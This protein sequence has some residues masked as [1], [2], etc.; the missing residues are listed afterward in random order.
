MR[1]AKK[2]FLN[3]FL[4][5][6]GLL[7]ICVFSYGLVANKLGYFLDDWYI[8]WTYRTFG[9]EKFLDFFKGD[10]PLFSYVY[11]VFIPLIKDSPL[12]WQLFAIFTK[13]LSGISLWCLLRL[14]MP[15]KDLSTFAIT[16]LFLVYPGFKFHHFAVMYSQNYAILAVYFLSHIFMI[17]AIRNPK[18]RCVYTI[19][20][21][22]LQFIGI[23][24]MELYYGL[25]LVRPILIFL[26]LRDD[27][28][29]LKV[30]LTRSFKTWLPY[31]LVLFG[32]TLFR[33]GFGQLYSYQLGLVNQL[34]SD[35]ISTIKQLAV[36]V[37]KAL[38]DS[39]F[40]VW[41][42][43][44]RQFHAAI[45]SG[46]SIVVGV[47]VAAGL[48]ALL[49][50]FYSHRTNRTTDSRIT[51]F[52]LPV[53]GVYI[54]LVGMIPVLI[55]GLDIGL[56]FHNN[57][58]LLHLSVGVCILIVSLVDLIIRQGYFRL[59]LLALLI[60][61]S[62][63][64]NFIV[65]NEYKKAWEAQKYFF[66]QLTWR[67]PQIRPG[68]V[69]ITPEVPFE[70]YYS[71]TSLTAPLNIIYSPELN[72]NPIP[73]Q[74]I[75]AGSPQ[76]KSMPELI[77]D[78]PIYRVSRAFNFQGNTSDMLVF[79]MPTRGC[80]QILSPSTNPQLYNNSRYAQLWEDL[81]KLSNLDR[82]VTNKPDAELPTRYFGSVP[83]RDW[84][85]YYQKAALAEQSQQWT[86]IVSLYDRAKSEQLNPVSSRELLPFI[87]AY[88]RTG[89]IKEALVLSE[90]LLTEDSNFR[91]DLCR[92]IEDADLMNISQDREQM[93]KFLDELKCEGD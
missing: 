67:V 78:Q 13:W 26:E 30:Q 57:R 92:I 17:L 76:M 42:D 74:M 53:L 73:Y 12:N 21:M 11:M 3:H 7:L 5:A 50:L 38:V 71:G 86:E 64:A 34:K 93:L 52:W 82:I 44:L 9:V 24:P 63:G 10:R 4:L 55:A 60:G 54:I 66:S 37:F 8:I 77:P 90:N 89:E 29:P 58:F 14:L 16:A 19:L 81:I 47:S 49:L 39:I 2:Q 32:F 15:K 46:N 1:V 31:L 87:N 65:G 68:T 75:L 72:Q 45:K 28:K 84:C 59:V 36:I 33:V 25:E 27:T 61:I 51:S 48:F 6:I 35:P 79:E 43:I 70:T 69:L 41:V 85:Y 20:A 80:L 56:A 83:Q 18:R 22:I 23:A 91:F 88:F 62:I 40:N